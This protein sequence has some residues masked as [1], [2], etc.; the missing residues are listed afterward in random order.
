MGI[1]ARFFCN[2]HLT[3]VASPNLHCRHPICKG[4]KTM[5][6]QVDELLNMLLPHTTKFVNY[7]YIPTKLGFWQYSWSDM[8]QFF[9]EKSQSKQPTEQRPRDCHWLDIDLTFSRQID[10]ES[11]TIRAPMPSGY[12][13]HYCHGKTAWQ[14]KILMSCWTCELFRTSR[15]AR[16][17][18]PIWVPPGADRTQVGPML[19]PWSLLSG[20][21]FLIV[22][23]NM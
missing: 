12:T 10:V 3:L 1:C 2:K 22:W 14:T 15:I 18:G 17:M 13:M 21:V 19:T 8:A 11:M 16:F 7:S 4:N 6:T 20:I 9:S 23:L 5:G